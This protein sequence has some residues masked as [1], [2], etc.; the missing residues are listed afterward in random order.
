MPP[1]P[2]PRDVILKVA[3]DLEAQGI[4]PT[5]RRVR[6]LSGGA[7]HWVQTVLQERLEQKAAQIAE[8]PPLSESLLSEMR[9]EVVRAVTADRAKRE[10]LV[11]KMQRLLNDAGEELKTIEGER[12]GLKEQGEVLRTER[13]T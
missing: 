9:G 11:G 13:D 6:P 4:E 5:T 8:M 1:K 10:D 7:S 12:D 3:A 2:V